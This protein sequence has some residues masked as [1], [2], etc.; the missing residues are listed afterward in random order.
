MPPDCTSAEPK[1]KPHIWKPPVNRK[2]RAK[3]EGKPKTST[4]VAIKERHEN[5][6]T[7]DWLQVFTF[8][9]K[10]P[11][12][13][14]IKVVDYFN[15]RPEGALVFTQATL[16]RCLAAR[17]TLEEH[18]ENEPGALSSKRRRMVT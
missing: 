9:E 16:L 17:K 1:C 6:T 8:M 10:N 7:Y 14:Q 3:K 18:I 5:L 15:S 12:M 4:K 2:P 11:G 13:S